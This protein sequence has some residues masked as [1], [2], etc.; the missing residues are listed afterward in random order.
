MDGTA[1]EIA[2]RPLRALPAPPQRVIPASSLQGSYAWKAASTFLICSLVCLAFL[3]GQQAWQYRQD[4]SSG[5]AAPDAGD[6]DEHGSVAEIARAEGRQV[7]GPLYEA[8]SRAMND[9]SAAKFLAIREEFAEELT[10][11]SWPQVYAGL[12]IQIDM[13]QL[14]S[15]LNAIEIE[16]S[17][18]Q[19]DRANFSADFEATIE[20]ELRGLESAILEL[21]TKQ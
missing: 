7:L 12:P 13:S 14:E 19:W 2:R 9:E 4:S 6:P 3:L 5:I 11:Y 8:E 20:E 16:M 15:E 1:A 18:T 10:N 17:L 21:E